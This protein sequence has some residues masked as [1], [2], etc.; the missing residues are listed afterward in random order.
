MQR[1]WLNY[2]RESFL[3]HCEMENS[4]TTL[5][6]N[7][8]QYWNLC[9]FFLIWKCLVWISCPFPCHHQINHTWGR[10]RVLRR[11]GDPDTSWYFWGWCKHIDFC[12]SFLYFFHVCIRFKVCSH[13]YN[14]NYINVIYKGKHWVLSCLNIQIWVFPF[15][16]CSKF[17]YLSKLGPEINLKAAY[18]QVS[19]LT[20]IRL[21]SILCFRAINFLYKYKYF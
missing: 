9:Y 15:E 4:I 14:I 1:F 3:R 19:I 7:H 10:I 17:S 6:I 12:S 5:I 18:F 2:V 11:D 20:F 8:S 21:A 16:H 13:P